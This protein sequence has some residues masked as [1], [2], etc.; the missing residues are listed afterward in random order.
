LNRLQA[1]LVEASARVPSLRERLA[2]AGLEPGEV[3]SFADLARVPI[4]RKAQL[5]SLQQ[6]CPPFG[7][8]LGVPVRDLERIYIS[9]GPI[10]DPQGPVADYWRWGEALA[11]AGFG[12][13][14]IVVNAFSYHLTPA[15]MMFDSALRVLGAVVVPTGVGNAELL[16]RA[17][18]DVGVTGYV[19]VPSFLYSLVEKTAELGYRWH[20]DIKL[21][22]AF[23]TAEKLPETLRQTLQDAY[24]ISVLQGYGTAD[25]G[26][27]AYECPS[28]T[29]LHL[30]RDV[31]ME[32]VDPDT[33]QRLAY[34]APGE[35]VVTLLNPTYPLVRFG[36]G[37]LGIMVGEPCPCGRTGPRLKGIYGRTSEGVKVRGL[38]V[39]PSQVRE[40]MARFPGVNCYQAVVTRDDSFKDVLTLRLEPAPGGP[41]PD[42]AEVIRQAKECLRLTVG[43]EIV[44]P[45]TL[46]EGDPILVDE[47]K[48]D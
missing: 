48:W 40:L 36:T 9:P 18:K 41:L 21:R 19:G 31:H 17:M 8:L 11:A 43:V 6:Q 47:R 38:F 35:V 2:A 12:A 44:Y 29:G 25:A 28:R 24:G 10:Y 22:K 3:T 27:L 4:M 7:G 34:G 32:I 46:K 5:V 33:G 45:G 30:A 15:G 13:G 23:V 14:D 1:F 42:T 26:C 16:V 39:Y 20:E 37:D